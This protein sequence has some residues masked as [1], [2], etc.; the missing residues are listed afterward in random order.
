[1]KYLQGKIRRAVMLFLVGI[2]HG[3]II[4]SPLLA[5]GF[6]LI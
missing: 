3:L 4:G 2:L 6:G 1:M 5:Y